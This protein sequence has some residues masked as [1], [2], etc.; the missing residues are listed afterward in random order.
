MAETT[1]GDARGLWP[2]M[3]K[4]AQAIAGWKRIRPKLRRYARRQLQR[5]IDPQLDAADGQ[6]ADPRFRLA[7][8]EFVSDSELP[9]PDTW[10]C[11]HGNRVFDTPVIHGNSPTAIRAAPGC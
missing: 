2:N 5:A 8:L 3:R 7:D 10:R 1:A 11:G 9:F 4:S 6:Q